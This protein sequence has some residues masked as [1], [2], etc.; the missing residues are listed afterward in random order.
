MN[1]DV[2]IT[3]QAKNDLRGI[4]KYITHVLLA[5]ENGKRPTRKT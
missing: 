4:Y 3:S 1:Y 5:P 2:R